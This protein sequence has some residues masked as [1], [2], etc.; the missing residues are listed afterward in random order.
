[1]LIEKLNN[2]LYGSKNFFL[3][4]TR[5]IT[6]LNTF[7]ALAL[8]I[9]I[10]GNTL[11]PAEAK[12]IYKLLDL[13][14]L[15]FIFTYLLRF[16]YAFQRT[17]FLKDTWFETLL[18]LIVVI[19]GT[20][21]YLFDFNLLES[22][23]RAMGSHNP[24][25]T[26]EMTINVFMLILIMVEIT[27]LSTNISLINLEPATFFLLSFILLILIG[28]GLLML[29]AMTTIPGSMPFI[30]ALF[31][32]TSAACVTGHIVVDTATFFTFK[33]KLVILVLVQLGGIGIVSF[34]SFFA[35]FIKKGVGIRHQ[36][37]I[38]DHLSAENLSSTK[39]ILRKVVFI[40][41]VIESIGM[42][43][44]FF[45]WGDHIT[46][47]SFEDRLFASIFHAVSAFNNAGF[48]IY[49]D[50][51]YNPALRN[52]Y[53]LHLVIAML[54]I[55]GGI[56]YATIEDLLS[57]RILRERLFNPWKEWKINTAF[58]V[59][60]SLFLIFLGTVV[61]Y[62][63]ERNNT[64]KEL[65]F[66]EGMITAF[67]QSVN[68][69]TAGFN[70]INFGAALMPTLILCYFLMFIGG[71]SA[72]TAGGIKTSTFM[73]ILLSVASTVRNK[74][75]IEISRRTISLEVIHKAY[76]ILIIAVG[77]NLFAFFL[78]TIT[79][80]NIAPMKLLFEE[81]S[82]FGTV[83]L[84]TN[85]LGE[86]S[87]SGKSILIFSMYLGRIGPLTLALALSS[88]VSSGAYKYPS[89]SVM[90]G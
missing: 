67:F 87:N 74:K 38:Q 22:I 90:V 49:T 41:L 73:L 20:S 79:E 27:K 60:T 46:F 1:M 56:G 44:I 17:Q 88:K 10:I 15:F 40:T 14:F 65:N 45:T 80:P 18:M 64:L 24:R 42:L 50:G 47:E 4:L 28:T 53:I 78:L 5:V 13:A 76:T 11:T 82:A 72:S 66:V 2:F 3:Q 43:L 23:F 54:I 7:T 51:M 33:G 32:S 68:T 26:Y 62:L 59:Y 83:G 84:S 48:S 9:Y 35:T 69:R 39:E 61:F 34:A 70:T 19:N 25:H 75:N 37:I 29:P 36:A 30:D 52:A 77:Y 85:V 71:S 58:A 31:T 55:V 21:I 81:I 63:L 6:F 86:F 12:K 89:A 16:T 8:L 57:P